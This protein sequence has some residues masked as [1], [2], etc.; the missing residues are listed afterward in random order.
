M[1]KEDSLFFEMLYSK[2]IFLGSHRGTLV[3]LATREAK[4]V[5]LEVSLGYTT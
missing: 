4:T 5:E 1:S 3:I 2:Y